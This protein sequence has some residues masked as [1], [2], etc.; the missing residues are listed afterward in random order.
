[1]DE[2]TSSV[3]A[4][5]DG[6]IQQELN[7]GSLSRSTQLLVAHRLGTVMHADLICVLDGGR[8]I[9]QGPASTLM[10]SP[11]SAFSQLIHAAALADENHCQRDR[12]PSVSVPSDDAF[13]M[14][15]PP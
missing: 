3:D 13:C 12:L 4:H 15:T 11:G 9:E 1:M 14:I 10:K 5:A 7:S 2:A 6:A 8:I